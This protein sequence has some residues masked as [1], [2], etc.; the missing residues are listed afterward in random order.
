MVYLR[1]FGG[2][3][4]A[5]SSLTQAQTS[6]NATDNGT[7]SDAPYK[8]PSLPV[9][10]R[11]QDLL[12]RMTIQD[13]MAQLVQGDISNWIN[14][15]TNVFNYSGLVANME[16]KAG[17]FYVSYPVPQQWIAEGVKQ[18][19]DYL[20]QNTTLGIPAL[21][22]SEG[23]HGFLIGDVSSTAQSRMRAPSTLIWSIRWLLPSLRNLL[24]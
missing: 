9:E 20:M 15:T 8:N 4:L 19:Q 22:Q 1:F 18:A 13:K 5:L 14:T 16:M 6:P 11:V 17:M 21:V 7:N 12:S 10:T 3:A 2:L 24:L 23:I